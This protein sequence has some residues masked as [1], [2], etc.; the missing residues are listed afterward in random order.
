AAQRFFY[1]RPPFL[2]PGTDRRLVALPCPPGRPLHAPAELLQLP[3][4]RGLG[5]LH[6][7]ALLDQHPNARQRPQLAR[8][9]RR[10]RSALERFDQLGALRIVEL[11]RTTK[12]FRSL[13][14]R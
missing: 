11:A 3:P 12:A 4:D 2:L 8:E 7:E 10:D 14:R 9:A 6:P 1:R 5:E 13:Q